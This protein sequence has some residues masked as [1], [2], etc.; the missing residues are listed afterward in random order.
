[1]LHAR[2]ERDTTASER[3]TSRRERRC[4]C[5]RLCFV[6]ASAAIARGEDDR[7]AFAA[8]ARRTAPRAQ[9]ST[10]SRRP[11]ESGV[12]RTHLSEH[13]LHP[14]RGLF[15]PAP[16]RPHRRG[17][18]GGPSRGGAAH[19]GGGEQRAPDGAARL[20]SRATRHR[21]PTREH[22]RRG[23][24]GRRAAARRSTASRWKLRLQGGV[25]SARSALASICALMSG[26][27]TFRMGN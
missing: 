13:H 20:E 7:G 10:R 6:A 5:F 18:R 22:A 17:A 8:R 16:L 21:T 25:F 15:R 3:E 4:P 14:S 27:K 12:A 26:K 1:V 9:P 2:V 11:R 19:G 23:L 24:D